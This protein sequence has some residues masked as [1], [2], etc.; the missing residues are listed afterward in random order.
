M[1]KDEFDF[2]DP[3]EL[4]GVA[5]LT[6]EDT[7]VAMCE[8]F[9]EEFLRMGWNHKQILALFQNPHYTGMNM[10]LENKGEQFVRDQIS[11]VFA[12]WGKLV[13]W[14]TPLVSPGNAHVSRA[15]VGVAPT[16]SAHS[17]EPDESPATRRDAASSTPEACAPQARWEP[18]QFRQSIASACACGSDGPCDSRSVPAAPPLDPL[19]NPAPDLTR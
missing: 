8:C 17:Q 3:L 19:G 15:V 12:R 9:I 10:V 2:D 13:E 7:S 18:I 4:N 1:P 6:D 14:K 16:T 11:D 5:L